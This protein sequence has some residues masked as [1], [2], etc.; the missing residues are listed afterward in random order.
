EEAR[1]KMSEAR[2]GRTLTEEHKRKIAEAGIGRKHTEAS[3]RKMSRVQK[4][5]IVSSEARQKLSEAHT[6]KTLTEE[7]KEKIAEAGL[8][9]KNHQ[10]IDGRSYE[11]Y[12]SEFNG[13]LKREIRRRDNETCQ[14]CFG[15][16][17]GNR[18]N[19]H[20]RNADKTDCRPENLILVCDSCHSLIHHSTKDTDNEMIL[21]FRSELT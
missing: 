8:G 7:H 18:G 6:G 5:R 17:K 20:H 1:R 2:S 16:A 19:V 13:V 15:S 10:W 12:T 14:A 11:P 3:K 4:G 9:D 21:K